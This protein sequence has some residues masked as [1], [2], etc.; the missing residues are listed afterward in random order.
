MIIIKDLS[1]LHHMELLRNHLIS[2]LKV[3]P[4]ILVHNCGISNFSAENCRIIILA[5]K[6]AD[7]YELLGIFHKFLHFKA[8]LK[9]QFLSLL[10][11]Y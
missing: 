4:Y 5:R 6:I 7:F 1:F 9:V 8:T 3:K 11:S 10:S 2:N